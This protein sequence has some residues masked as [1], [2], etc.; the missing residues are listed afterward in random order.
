MF[1]EEVQMTVNNN[2]PYNDSDDFDPDFPP[3]D[4]DLELATDID[5]AAGKTRLQAAWQR[6]EERR[7][8]TWLRDQTA[9]W[10]YWDDYLRPQ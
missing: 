5:A 8:M 7:E 3:G 10:D 6:I 4:D 1:S 9:D 2:D